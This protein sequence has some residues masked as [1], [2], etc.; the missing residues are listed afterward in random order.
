MINLLVETKHPLSL[1]HCVGDVYALLDG[2]MM[3][4][5]GCVCIAVNETLHRA[6]SSP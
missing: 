2:I 6:Y 4:A 5:D 3:L 1:A